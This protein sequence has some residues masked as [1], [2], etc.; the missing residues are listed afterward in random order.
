MY[1]ITLTMA[2]H[3]WAGSDHMNTAEVR[4]P[5][6]LPVDQEAVSLNTARLQ[7]NSNVSLAHKDI[8]STNACSYL[9]I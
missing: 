8:H 6:R 4:Q 5:A 1:L 7:H 3:V 2:P 9:Q